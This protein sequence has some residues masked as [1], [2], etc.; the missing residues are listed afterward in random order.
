MIEQR[1]DMPFGYIKVEVDSDEGVALIHAK[2]TKWGVGVYKESLAVWGE[3]LNALAD[4]GITAV[5][6][7]I[8]KD[9]KIRKFQTMFGL[10]PW[11]QLDEGLVYRKELS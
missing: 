1:I 2:A 10:S 4:V 8:P 11:K 3:I 6:S 9:E 5:I 7:F